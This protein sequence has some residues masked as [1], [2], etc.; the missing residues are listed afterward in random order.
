LY[1]SE[2]FL[3]VMSDKNV[4]LLMQSCRN[5]LNSL[6]QELINIDNLLPLLFL[7]NGKMRETGNYMLYILSQ[8][9][10]N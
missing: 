10:N 2:S 9:Y 1:T 6:T 3:I 8:Y 5:L 7:Q 4:S